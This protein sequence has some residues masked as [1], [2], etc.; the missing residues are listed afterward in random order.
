M[1]EQRDKVWQAILTPHRSLS[2]SGFL[3]VM[4]LVIAI[5]LIVGISFVL[6]GAWPV[7]GFAGL[8]VLVIWLAF[9]ANFAAARRAE[10][11]SITEHEVVLERLSERQ[12]G[13]RQVFVRRWVRVQLEEDRE[14]E[15][16]GALY[17][18]SGG[19]KTQVGDFLGGTEKKEL[20]TALSAAM[21]IA[22]I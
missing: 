11:I 8:D 5:N 15:L 2:R 22:H 6:A 9:R 16:V 13:D 10:R 17:L 7:F 4:G 19:R 18:V 20:A 14:R 1:M 3:T 21:A 12:G